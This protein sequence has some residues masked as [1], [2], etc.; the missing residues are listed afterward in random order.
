MKFLLAKHGFRFSKSKGQNFLTASWVPREI[1][2]GAGVDEDCGVLEIG[3]GFGCLTEQLCLRAGKVVAIEVDRSLEPVLA[4]TMAGQNNLEIIF[5]DALKADLAALVTERFDGLRP[6]ACAN[7]PY[8]ITSPVIA[9]LLEA[10]CFSCVTVMVQKEVAERICAR[11]ATADYSAF[12]ILCQY[13]AEPEILFDVPADCFMPRPKVTS[14]VIRLN[15]RTEPPCDV[16][17]EAFFFRTVRA[18]FALRR[19]TLV[20]S[21]ATGFGSLP[22]AELTEAVT[23]C[24]LSPTVRGETL[25]LAAYAQL[26]AALQAR[27]EG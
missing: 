15:C 4:E 16:A 22:K 24:G 17:D 27:L 5:G 3:P 10:K 25:D 21:L 23:E 1:A 11:P 13:Y 2:E 14:S 19:K 20:N 12:S 8:Y 9:A 26:A 7:L 18:G 6:V